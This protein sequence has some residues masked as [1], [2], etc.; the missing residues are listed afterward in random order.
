M[1]AA[2]CDVTDAR[3]VRASLEAC[4]MTFGGVDIVI[5][6]AGV[7]ADRRYR[8]LFGGRPEEKF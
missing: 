3:Q 4:S 6:N 1:C 7:G 5:S 2:V 8:D